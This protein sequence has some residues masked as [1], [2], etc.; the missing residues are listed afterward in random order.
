[1]KNLAAIANFAYAPPK[2]PA[3]SLLSQTLTHFLLLFLAIAIS[4]DYPKKYR[5][6]PRRKSFT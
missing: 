4:H 1:M 3:Q 6:T 2:S 5:P